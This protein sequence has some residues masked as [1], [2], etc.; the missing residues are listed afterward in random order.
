MATAD[1][2]ICTTGVPGLLKKEMIRKGQVIL[3]LSNPKPEIS[4]ED[5]RAAGASFAADG[6]GANNALAF[7]GLFRGALNARA[8]RAG[9]VQRDAPDQAVEPSREDVSGVGRRAL[10]EPDRVDELQE[11]APRNHGR[12]RIPGLSRSLREQPSSLVIEQKEG[13]MEIPP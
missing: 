3:A 8:R 10:G 5:A 12:R 2:V 6:R 7:P 4:P 9:L 11:R 1:I 13:G